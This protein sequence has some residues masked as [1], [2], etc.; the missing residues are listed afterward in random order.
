MPPLP[1]WPAMVGGSIYLGRDWLCRVNSLWCQGRVERFL[2]D[3]MGLVCCTM[4]VN[5]VLVISREVAYPRASV[6]VE[7]EQDGA[8]WDV[9]ERSELVIIMNRGHGIL[10]S[11][12]GEIPNKL[13]LRAWRS[14]PKALVLDICA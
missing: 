9:G 6:L 1:S 10:P 12:G 2:V 13:S 8:T 11:S 4:N 14:P 3:A 5:S 7:C